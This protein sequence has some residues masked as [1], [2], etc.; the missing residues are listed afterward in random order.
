MPQRSCVRD[1]GRPLA[2]GLQ[3][4][5]ANHRKRLGSKAPVVSVTEKAPFKVSGMNQGRRTQVN[6]RTSVVSN[7]LT[8]K[9][10]LDVTPGKVWREPVYWSGGV[11]RRGGVILIRALVWNCGNLRWRCQGKGTSVKNEAESTEASSRDGAIRSSNEGSV[12]ELERRD[13]IIRSL[14]LVN[15]A[16][17]RSC[18]Q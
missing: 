4:Q 11:R 2:I 6:H 14:E 16:S 17:R 12:M 3:E 1:E 9:L 8:S 15:C 10:E 5:V 13:C 18:L 7:T